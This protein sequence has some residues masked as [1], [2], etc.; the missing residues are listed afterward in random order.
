MKYLLIVGFLIG[1]CSL[2]LAQENKS[3]IV[4][5]LDVTVDPAIDEPLYVVSSMKTA[6]IITKDQFE[7][8]S[9]DDID[10]VKVINDPSA[11]HIYGD[12]ARHGVVLVVLKGTSFSEK[13]PAKKRRER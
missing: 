1:T 13:Y 3:E 10:Y 8:I 2:G 11:I 12:K 9:H 7:K 6:K 4:A 5:E